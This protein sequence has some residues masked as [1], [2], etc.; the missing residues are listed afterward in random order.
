MEANERRN[1]QAGLLS[2]LSGGRQVGSLSEVRIGRALE[3]PRTENGEVF[4]YK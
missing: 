2:L 1:T 3:V 4:G